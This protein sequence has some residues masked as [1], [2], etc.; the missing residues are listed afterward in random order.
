M[1]TGLS[2]RRLCY[3]FL[4]ISIVVA[5]MFMFMMCSAEAQA[6]DLDLVEDRTLSVA[7][8]SEGEA[9]FHGVSVVAPV[10]AINGGA[11]INAS[12][13]RVG[14][15]KADE[16]QWRI[17]GGP[18]YR[19]MSVQFY[20]DSIY[21]ERLDYA[22]FFRPGELHFGNIS[23]SG[24]LGTLLRQETLVE[25]GEA[26]A[27]ADRKVK[28]LAFVSAHYDLGDLD[29]DVRATFIPGLDGEHDISAEPSA[30]IDRGRFSLTGTGFFGYTL[31][32]FASDYTLL[33]NVPF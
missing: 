28:G 10:G 13:T 15:V 14:E 1:F 17:Q 32:R 11:F 29:F 24:G 19:G 16:L 33:V 25:L 3:L 9:K 12:R 31:G 26:D 4:L 18:V 21:E 6:P 7:L 22:W 5:F 30:T 23:V 27:S 2:F 8:S 20:V